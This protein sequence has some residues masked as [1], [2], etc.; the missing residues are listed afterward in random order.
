MVADGCEAGSLVAVNDRLTAEG[1]VPRFIATTLGAIAPRAGDD[2][3]VDVSLEATPSVLYDAVVLPDGR[4]AI[5]RLRADGRAL[6]FIKE[7]YRHCKSIL[8]LGQ[9]AELLDACGISP[10]LPNGDPD[11]GIIIGAG[12]AAASSDAFIAAIA[13][14]RHFNRETD[15]PRV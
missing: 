9:G 13:K 10:S 8:A 7:Q 3:E 4:D 12:D 11:P 2:L 14:H 1:A 15:P 5:A 6:E